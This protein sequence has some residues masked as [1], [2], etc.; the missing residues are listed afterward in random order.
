MIVIFSDLD[1]TLLD[2][3]T[4]SFAPALPALQQLKRFG[5]PLV[6]CTSKTRAEVEV[7]QNALQIDAPFVV[8]NGGA[9]FARPGPFT[10]EPQDWASRDGYRVLVL[11]A[12]YRALVDG[13]RRASAESGAR[14]RGFS[15]MTDEEV[16]KETGLPLQ[17][18]RL[19]RRR[20]FD[21][22]FVL[23]TPE[24]KSDLCAAIERQGYRWTQGGRF[25]HIM[26][27][28]NKAL[29]VE[30]LIE[31]YRRQFGQ[32]R[33]VGLGDAPNDLEFL[34]KVDVPVVI[35]SRRVDQMQKEIPEARV[36][37]LPGPAGWGDAVVVLLKEM[38]NA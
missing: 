32:V 6:L 35:Q 24:R 33:T 26:G 7:L 10:P 18:A 31:L 17:Q 1:G 30:K 25:F 28:S 29:A 9:V 13:L 2:E 19:A 37:S 36:T 15:E 4:Y 20:E 16:S 22:A 27:P 3:E 14:T 34:R 21:E 38:M 11:G 8:E 12:E 23:E 5:V